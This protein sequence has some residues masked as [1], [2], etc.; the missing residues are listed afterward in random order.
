MNFPNT[1]L[2]TLLISSSIFT[3]FP[4]HAIS[5]DDEDTYSETTGD[6]REREEQQKLKASELWQILIN[7]KTQDIQKTLLKYTQNVLAYTPKEYI[8]FQT[9]EDELLKIFPHSPE[10]LSAIAET[11]LIL[12]DVFCNPLVNIDEES[13][14]GPNEYARVYDPTFNKKKALDRFVKAFNLAKQQKKNKLAATIAI[15]IANILNGD[16]NQ[17]RDTPTN[18]FSTGL[19]PIEA[20]PILQTQPQPPSPNPSLDQVK[21]IVIYRFQVFQTP[22]SWEEAKSDGERVLW[23]FQEAK[24]LNPKCKNEVDLK[25][26]NLMRIWFAQQCVP[27]SNDIVQNEAYHI[28]RKLK[29]NEYYLPSE[30]LGSSEE[31][32]QNGRVLTL[33]GANDY[34]QVYRNILKDDP[35]QSDVSNYLAME[36]WNRGMFTEAKKVMDECLKHISNED[37]EKLSRQCSFLNDI[38]HPCLRLYNKTDQNKISQ[39]ALTNDGISIL[40]RYCNSP[41][42]ILT[43]DEIDLVQVY[44]DAFDE[45]K[46][47]TDPNEH[48]RKIGKLTYD[49]LWESTIKPQKDRYCKQIAEISSDFSTSRSNEWFNEEIKLPINKEG[50]Y[51]IEGK[52]NTVK[53]PCFVRIDPFNYLL[54]NTVNGFEC[55]SAYKDTGKP[56]VKAQGIFYVYMRSKDKILHEQIECVSDE[57]GIF[58]IK[59]PF[60][61][62]IDDNGNRADVYIGGIISQG[63]KKSVIEPTRLEC[64]TDS[65][66]KQLSEKD[67]KKATDLQSIYCQ[68]DRPV[69]FPGDTI[70]GQ[71]VISNY[72]NSFTDATPS[73]ELLIETQAENYPDPFEKINNKIIKTPNEFG[74]INFDIP[75]PNTS[76]RESNRRSQIKVQITEKD[77]NYANTFKVDIE[78]EE[79]DKSPINITIKNNKI[80]YGKPIT[81]GFE[82]SE[83]S[84]VPK[85]I[86]KYILTYKEDEY[87]K[88]QSSMD[89]WMQH[90]FRTAD[91]NIEIWPTRLLNDILTLDDHGQAIFSYNHLFPIKLEPT[92]Q[93][94]SFCYQIKGLYINEEG[95]SFPI[96]KTYRVSNY[97]LLLIDYPSST[98]AT[99]DKPY[100]ITWEAHSVMGTDIKQVKGN[101]QLI[102]KNENAKAV[103][104]YDYLVFEDTNQNPT[105]DDIIQSW[106][107]TTDEKGKAKLDFIP[108]IAGEYRLKGTWIDQEGGISYTDTPL[109]IVGDNIQSPFR[110]IQIIP[111]KREYAPNEEVELLITAPSDGGTIWFDMR[112]GT[113]KQTTQTYPIDKGY[114][115][116]RIKPDKSD[117]SNFEVMATHAHNQMS[118]TKQ[119]SI[120]ILPDLKNLDIVTS[121]TTDIENPKKGQLDVQVQDEN[122]EPIANAL[123]FVSIYDANLDKNSSSRRLNAMFPIWPKVNYASK[124][125]TGSSYHLFSSRNY[126]AF[127]ISPRFYNGNDGCAFSIVSNR[128]ENLKTSYIGRHYPSK[129]RNFDKRNLTPDLPN[130]PIHP[131][132]DWGYSLLFSSDIQTDAQ[133]KASIPFTLPLESSSWRIKVKAHTKDLKEGYTQK[134]WNFEKP[135]ND[136]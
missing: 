118:A 43:I 2:S 33:T 135:K 30:T 97:P 6:W 47:I 24:R 60:E 36:L 110:S 53:Y 67:S 70:K 123:L 128:D 69:Y 18:V 117:W 8:D 104:T 111:S 3:I 99:Q 74:I 27:Y 115:I 94:Q 106:T 54:R 52:N 37:K 13:E 127:Y 7:N 93:F 77:S 89:H 75:L 108:T 80:E 50:I 103:S 21:Q 122:G 55:I 126:R 116:I 11:Y 28:R 39:E 98:F 88:N 20:N 96:E 17:F 66:Q 38:G 87:E 23:L 84:D 119:K 132:Y 91:F 64:I 68:F 10:H 57:M 130:E 107:V 31:E 62:V 56:V 71:C 102:R 95:Q 16:L 25:W 35:K 65:N 4:L 72:D 41:K 81:M 100:H 44:K 26:A 12:P 9:K 59:T 14:Y 51:A 90:E 134:L 82:A 76:K 121:I 61:N 83:S 73:K 32:S 19:T 136:N 120:W 45:L 15:R 5:D 58:K 129:P 112:A 40:A 46:T 49:S 63:D 124:I 1:F 101:I 42:D 22:P 125:S 86:I 109:C 85:G 114:K 92:K 48:A 34:I 79:I 131:P 105:T 113:Q 133:G 78:N 29:V